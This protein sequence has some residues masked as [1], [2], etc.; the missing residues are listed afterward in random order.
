MGEV[1]N[2]QILARQRILARVAGGRR[3]VGV[4]FEEG[5]ADI[6]P[7]A[8]GGNNKLGRAAE[9][10]VS[11]QIVILVTGQDQIFE[12]RGT[13][14]NLNAIVGAVVDLDMVKLRAGA[15]RSEEHTSELQSLMRISYAVFCLKK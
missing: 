11:V 5:V 4:G 15:A 12:V 9:A 14:E 13:A 6:I 2:L 1:S 7:F 10:D 3:T 8:L